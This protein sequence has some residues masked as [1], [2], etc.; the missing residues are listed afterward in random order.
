LDAVK[1]KGRCVDLIGRSLNIL[2][3]TDPIKALKIHLGNSATKSARDFS[4]KA[5]V[6]LYPEKY[7]CKVVWPTIE[8][9]KLRFG[10]WLI[11]GQ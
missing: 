10:T 3:S 11:K 7:F 6:L 9:F 1:F 8:H 5:I 2:K 4:K